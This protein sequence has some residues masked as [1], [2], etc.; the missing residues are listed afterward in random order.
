[1]EK[2]KIAI[3]GL[4]EFGS[5]LVSW[6]QLGKMEGIEILY[7]I[8]P[9]KEKW[10]LNNPVCYACLQDVPKNLRTRTQVI[11]D[12]SPK[13]C[14]ASNLE[15]YKSFG[16]PAVFQNGES[17]GL[18]ELFYSRNEKISS[19]YLKVAK[20]SAL[21]T[22]VVTSPLMNALSIQKIWCSHFKV[23][24]HDRM[25]DFD[26]V[27]GREITALLGIEAIVDVTY[28][29]GISHN[30]Y[31]YHGFIHVHCAKPPSRNVAL[32]ILSQN[33]DVIVVG[34]NIDT[35]SFPRTTKTLVM[36]DGIRVSGNVLQ[37]PVL[38]F[39]PEINFPQN[40]IAIRLL[41]KSKLE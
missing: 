7:C 28:L 6:I 17:L 11:V 41:T 31:V 29:R 16:L 25:V 10:G 40:E 12:C 30:G 32:E 20:C 38:S 34:K 36:K 27:S 1:M 19:R 15:L 5:Q 37:I 4:G 13:G 14:G 8:E 22:C 9:N 23:N 39:T 18:C 21:S 2:V 3:A 24:N 26:Y 35:R 33:P